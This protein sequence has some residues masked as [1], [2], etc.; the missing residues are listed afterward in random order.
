[1]VKP[2]SSVTRDGNSQKTKEDAVKAMVKAL[3]IERRSRYSD[4][5][6]KRSTFSQF[7][8][9]SSARLCRKYPLESIWMT[10]RGL[11]RQYPNTDVATRISIVRRADELL[12]AYNRGMGWTLGRLE[13]DVTSPAV[14]ASP[15]AASS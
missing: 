6:G 5:H 14:A 4:F 15:A 1:M 3:D 13:E 9:Q 10:L 7:M 2:V 8:R 12:A 11:F